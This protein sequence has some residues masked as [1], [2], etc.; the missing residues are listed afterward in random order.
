MAIG[1]E[2]PPPNVFEDTSLCTD[3]ATAGSAT[4][5]ADAA[6]AQLRARRA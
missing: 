6:L 1:C 2:V 5:T 3:R 4:A